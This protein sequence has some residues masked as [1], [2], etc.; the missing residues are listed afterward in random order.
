MP[1]NNTTNTESQSQAQSGSVLQSQAD[2]STPQAG[3]GTQTQTP[4]TL[5]ALQQQIAELRAENAKHRTNA[6]AQ[7]AAAQ[8]TEQQRLAEQGEYKK[9]AE[10]HEARVKELEPVSERY[11]TLALQL[12]S[13]IEAEVKD[14]PAELKAFDPGKDAPVE[15]RMV[16]LQKSRPLLEKLQQQQR[17][18]APGNRPNP[19][20]AGPA[21]TREEADKRNR[22]AFVRQRNYGI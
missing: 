3:N 8:A 7:K 9:L 4:Q 15:Q 19:A 17:G 13:Q 16:W 11:S 10:Q 20:H 1:D 12:A 14:W 6:N 18:Q 22:Q 5:D 21:S 2:N